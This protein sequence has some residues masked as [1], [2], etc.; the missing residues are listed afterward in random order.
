MIS[1]LSLLITGSYNGG[2]P[3]HHRD[4][5][6]SPIP[7]WP[8]GSS[9]TEESLSTISKL[10]SENKALKESLAQLQAVKDGQETNIQQLEIRYNAI[11][12]EKD[13]LRDRTNALEQQVQELSTAKDSLTKL[14]DAVGTNLEA[15]YYKQQLEL[16][17]QQSEDQQELAIKLAAAQAEN[18]GLQSEIHRLECMEED[19]PNIE[20]IKFTHAAMKRKALEGLYHDGTRAAKKMKVAKDT[21]LD[22]KGFNA[23]EACELIGNV[24][25]EVLRAASMGGLL[26][27]EH[28][29]VGPNGTIGLTE[30]GTKK[31]AISERFREYLGG[32][33]GWRKDNELATKARKI[34]AKEDFNCDGYQ[35]LLPLTNLLNGQ[36]EVA[37]EDL[38]QRINEVHKQTAGLFMELLSAAK[39]LNNN[40]M[41]ILTNEMKETVRKPLLALCSTPDTFAILDNNLLPGKTCRD[42]VE[43]IIDIT[44]SYNNLFD[45][46]N[47]ILET[48]QLPPEYAPSSAAEKT[49][50]RSLA[51]QKELSNDVESLLAA[52]DI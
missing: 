24:N 6:F 45:L 11:L 50:T 37:P 52:A 26:N 1:D 14:E 38:L 23:D 47:E 36:P 7:V 22:L 51:A 4:S 27:L 16:T 41:E 5:H 29:G 13:Q 32:F 8:S 12:A 44:K 15:L 34:M 25:H 2:A 21:H 20:P 39:M 49:L 35:F 31:L 43:H 3:F 28:F 46:R 30:F 9:H 42:M 10:E 17:Y 33:E 19:D 40:C 18:V 48:A